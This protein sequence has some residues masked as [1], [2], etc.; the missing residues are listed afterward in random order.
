MAG[1]GVAH[2]KGRCPECGRVIS[3]RAAGPEAEH[4]DRRWVLLRPHNRDQTTRHPVVCLSP[5]G[6][7][8]VPRV[9]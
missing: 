6:Y 9:G 8:K 1:Q 7:R 5:G 4:A 3:G 2:A